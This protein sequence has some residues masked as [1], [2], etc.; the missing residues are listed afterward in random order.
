MVIDT[1]AIIAILAGEP[2]K[3]TF[4]EHIVSAPEA[5]L[6]AASYVETGIV[7]ERFPDIA[8]QLDSFLLELG[9]D[10]T[11]VTSAQARIA[12]EAYRQFGKGRHP[13]GLN[14]GDCF[15]YALTKTSGHRLLFKGN[16][17]GKTDIES[18]LLP[19]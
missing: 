19:H 5:L 6:S 9:I 17:F 14:Y 12:R 3:D 18:A 15:S 1:S 8:N 11:P 4:L 10:V 16:D 7:V 2:E 13:A